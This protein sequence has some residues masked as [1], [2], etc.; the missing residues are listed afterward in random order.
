[1]PQL[2]ELV[3]RGAQAILLGCTE[4]DLFVGPGDAPVLL[5]DTTRLHAERAAKIA[6]AG[7]PLLTR[8]RLL[9]I[10]DETIWG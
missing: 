1:V 4:I 5:F 6:L 8:W 3:D 2:R 10:A 7:T 9:R